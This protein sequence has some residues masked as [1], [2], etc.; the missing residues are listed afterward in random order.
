MS[1][2]RYPEE[3]KIEAIKQA[4]DRG[5]S[6]ASSLLRSKFAIA[7]VYFTVMCGVIIH[8][9]PMEERSELFI[10]IL[11]ILFVVSHLLLYPLASLIC[12][13]NR[14]WLTLL[15]G[16]IPFHVLLFG[17][18][19]GSIDVES[20]LLEP[21]WMLALPGI[22]WVIG[23]SA[24]ALF[25]RIKGLLRIRWFQPNAVAKIFT[26]FTSLLS[27]SIGLLMFLWSQDFSLLKTPYFLEHFSGTDVLISLIFLL[28][29]TYIAASFLNLISRQWSAF[30]FGLAPL[31]LAISN[32]LADEFDLTG[33]ESVL[34]SKWIFLGAILMGLIWFSKE[35]KI[36]SKTFGA[37]F[38]LVWWLTDLI[39]ALILLLLCIL[40][41]YVVVALVQNWA[42]LHDIGLRQ[43]L[44]ISVKSLW[45]WT[46]ILI[47]AISG[48]MAMSTIQDYSVASLYCTTAGHGP[49]TIDSCVS[50]EV[51]KDLTLKET[52]K[53][54]IQNTNQYYATRAAAIED[55]KKDANSKLKRAKKETK[56]T[57]IDGYNN[58]VPEAEDISILEKQTCGFFDFPCNIG[59]GVRE[60]IRSSYD[61]A[62]NE[63]RNKLNEGIESGDVKVDDVAKSLAENLGEIEAAHVAMLQNTFLAL[64]TQQLISNVLLFFLCLRSFLYVFARVAFDGGRL[65][66]V[67][68]REDDA[69]MKRGTIKL[70]GAEYTIDLTRE[71]PVFAARQYQPQGLAPRASLP[72]P[73]TL[74]LARI[75]NGAWVMNYLEAGSDNPKV[76]FSATQ[77]QEFVVWT[78]KPDEI[79][80]FNFKHFVA[81]SGSI[82][83]SSLISLRISSLL[84]GK[85]VFATAKGPG[86]LV[87]KSFGKAKVGKTM[88]EIG[89]SVAPTRLL[90][91]QKISRFSIESNLSF[92]D[93]YLSGFN[94]RPMKNDLVLIDVDRQSNQESGLGRF[95]KNFLK[96][97]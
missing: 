72:Q 9:V 29:I 39:S 77:G 80:I 36:I 55:W 13:V 51:R 75:L 4:V 30:F 88:E 20:L 73:S 2:K 97:W 6:I 42:V 67:S 91:W 23:Q 21:S 56:K 87:L 15:F 40:L 74:L 26:L 17:W 49:N 85:I 79:V 1:G 35:G 59:N 41:R 3:F 82:K 78:L 45:Y 94:I 47:L 43:S 50:K 44:R 70:A 46:P 18:V 90:A 69:P 7:L 63:N 12:L 61:N 37:I 76:K 93:I 68:L 28:V 60:S 11:L 95:T 10:Y 48:Y 22:V 96:P 27:A 84:F 32:I 86:K 24:K 57:V 65:A 64:S 33:L 62:R 71:G 25:G 81:M 83:L 31:H 54:S 89:A 58:S 66:Y 19:T 38:L 8:L 53:N 34:Q 14:M 5:Y 92:V 52:Q 16:L